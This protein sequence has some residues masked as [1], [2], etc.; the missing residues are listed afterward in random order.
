M[1]T[2]VMMIT[3]IEQLTA[4]L[5]AVPV[6]WRAAFLAVPRHHFLPPQVW[7]DDDQ[8]KPRPLSR[9]DDHDQ[10]L[11]SAY[12]NV[13]VLTQFDDGQTVWPDTSGELC[14]SAASNPASPRSRS[15]PYWPTL[16]AP[17]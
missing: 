9:D 5:D 1:M 2:T 3:T 8:G 10:W 11:E 4:E 17:Q 15:T 14:T 12:R 6:A 13:P 16:P 7:M